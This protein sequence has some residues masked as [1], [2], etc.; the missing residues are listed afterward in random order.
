MAER[1]HQR[2]LLRAAAVLG[3]INALAKRLKVR[4]GLLL[5]W[6]RGRTRV[7]QQVFLAAVEIVLERDLDIVPDW[8]QLGPPQTD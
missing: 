3:G 8:A 4:P 6:M 2:T 7:P 1:V 5:T